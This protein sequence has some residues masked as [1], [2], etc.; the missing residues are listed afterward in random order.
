MRSVLLVAMVVSA[1]APVQPPTD[2]LPGTPMNAAERAVA[3]AAARVRGLA[4]DFGLVAPAAGRE[5]V[6]PP[7][8]RDERMRLAA[9]LAEATE[10]LRRAAAVTSTSGASSAQSALLIA[11][12]WVASAEAATEAELT[13][14]MLDPSFDRLAAR[15]ERAPET[16]PQAQAYMQAASRN[17]RVTSRSERDWALTR[18]SSFGPPLSSV[19][20]RYAETLAETATTPTVFAPALRM[21]LG[22]TVAVD[23]G[24]LESRSRRRLARARQQLYGLA[25]A[26]AP[27]GPGQVD[28]RVDLASASVRTSTAPLSVER[29]TAWLRAQGLEPR[30]KVVATELRNL[31]ALFADPE[32]SGPPPPLGFPVPPLTA[33]TRATVLMARFVRDEFWALTERF[34]VAELL[35]ERWARAHAGV[36][37][38]L[39][40][41]AE[42]MRC[43]EEEGLHEPDIAALA[44]AASR[45]YPGRDAGL[46]AALEMWKEGQED[47]R[48]PTAPAWCRRW[49]A[50][51]Q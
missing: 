32:V 29:L 12:G 49:A 42:A 39:G 2:R 25:L 31:P 4:G 7:V 18:M 34:V 33:R 41:D 44:L 3:R 36:L 5:T 1:C 23:F 46:V 21:A 20:Q 15:L 38:T 10:T 17:V 50:F 40:R 24:Q 9:A 26:L 35:V 13:A 6:L 45:A 48:C 47:L 43:L 19:V 11:K 27:V 22:A 14:T 8:T 16:Q 37:L 28:A 30:T 51:A